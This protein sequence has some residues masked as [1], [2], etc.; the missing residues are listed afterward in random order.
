MSFVNDT[1][2]IHV[3]PR[4]DDLDQGMGS[5]I[6]PFQDGADYYDSPAY[7]TVYVPQ[8]RDLD[9]GGKN[10]IALISSPISG[11]PSQMQAEV[12]PTRWSDRSGHSGR[13]SPRVETASRDT[14]FISSSLDVYNPLV[15][16]T[17][18]S[19]PLHNPQ[20]TQVEQY[21]QAG[22]GFTTPQHGAHGAHYLIQS[23]WDIEGVT[24][25]ESD[26]S[27]S[28]DPS[29]FDGVLNGMTGQF[30]VSPLACPPL[31]QPDHFLPPGPQ[32]VPIPLETP[33]AIIQQPPDFVA[34]PS[35]P[36]DATTCQHAIPVKYS[37]NPADNRGK[38][39]KKPTG[40]ERLSIKHMRRVGA[41]IRCRVYRMKC[42]DSGSVCANCVKALVGAK[43]FTQPC[44]RISL[45]EVVPHRMGNSLTG[46]VRSSLPN[47]RWS[48]D[49]PQQK[50][51]LLSHLFP[52]SLDR[53]YQNMPSISVKCR[54]FVPG[55]T[56]HLSDVRESADGRQQVTTEYPPYACL[57]ANTSKTQGLINQYL[58]AFR[59]LAEEAIDSVTT[60]E[61][62]RLGNLE[63]RRYAS[64]RGGI[65]SNALKIRAAT[66]VS[67]RRLIIV[68]NDT[69]GIKTFDNPGFDEYGKV[70]SPISL[71]LQL[72]KLYITYMEQHWKI[73]LSGLKKLIFSR[74]D[75]R[76]TWYEVFLTVFV[77]LSTLEC[78]H[79]EEISFVKAY[80]SKDN[81]YATADYVKRNMIEEWQA[82]AKNLIYHFRVVIRGTVPF[83]QE[84]T[85]EMQEKAG[86]DDES[87]RFIRRIGALVA[88]RRRNFQHMQC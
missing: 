42:D 25:L 35:T 24:Q 66:Y 28:L 47:L 9:Q 88:A 11:V 33:Q 15:D 69:L 36:E 51:V 14:S 5:D 22:Y 44:L 78:A 45:K 60:D 87:V 76:E 46:E 10:T 38:K 41:C 59:P 40:D 68:G 52:S 81:I 57:D 72:D 50:K 64:L 73:V 63:A 80:A 1:D 65:V 6:F 71:D 75:K 49:Y 83:S 67:E 18:I 82:S 84:W 4:G 62:I 2:N 55:P 70:L 58:D 74:T 26:F 79:A 77:L 29:Y 13:Y 53:G 85:P 19:T 37:P 20:A 16:S 31:P 43:V 27:P 48:L 7:F 34:H 12:L 8:A 21:G 54:R 3:I 56:E 61:I 32:P 30:G 23:P 86:I 17:G 39:R